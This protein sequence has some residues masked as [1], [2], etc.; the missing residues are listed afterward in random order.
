MMLGI[1]SMSRY[2]GL[3]RMD[4]RGS[5]NRTEP[6]RYGRRL[7]QYPLWQRGSG[8]PQSNNGVRQTTRQSAHCDPAGKT[9]P[10][11]AFSGGVCDTAGPTSAAFFTRTV[12]YLAPVGNADGTQAISVAINI[13]D[14]A[15]GGTARYSETLL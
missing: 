14:A 9:Q 2:P 13:F 3:M 12:D 7:R 11:S 6:N 1:I 10:A 15:S 5:S 4:R 8:S